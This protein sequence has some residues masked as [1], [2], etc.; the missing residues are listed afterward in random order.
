MLLGLGLEFA[1]DELP[2]MEMFWGVKLH[3]ALSMLLR[4]SRTNMRT[5]FS[6]RSENAPPTAGLG[7]VRHRDACLTTGETYPAAPSVTAPV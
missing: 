1:D 5:H 3:C 7:S 6:A 4:C 2:E